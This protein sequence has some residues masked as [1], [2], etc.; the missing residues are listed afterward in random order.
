MINLVV[1]RIRMTDPKL[2]CK[3]S[4]QVSVTF[5][6]PIALDKLKKSV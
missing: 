2:I 4:G 5:I 3:Y 6:N 1:N